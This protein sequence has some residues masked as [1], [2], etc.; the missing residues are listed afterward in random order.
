MDGNEVR[1]KTIYVRV[2]H[3]AGVTYESIR[4]HQYVL[5][6]LRLAGLV[7]RPSRGVYT[8]TAKGTEWLQS[9]NGLTKANL[10]GV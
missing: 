5:Q 9:G 8:I 4:R 1:R 10:H 3:L 6:D 2:A 7:E